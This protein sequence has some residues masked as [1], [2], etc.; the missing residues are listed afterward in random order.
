MIMFFILQISSWTQEPVLSPM[1]FAELRELEEQTISYDLAIEMQA[2]QKLAQY[3]NQPAALE[4]FL[5][6]LLHSNAAIQNYVTEVLRNIDPNI[7][8]AIPKAK[9]QENALLQ[10][11]VIAALSV[12]EHSEAPQRIFEL[13]DSQHY[14]CVKDA[15][16]ALV[17][18]GSLGK[19][20]IQ[21]IL[22]PSN[23]Q[24]Q[25]GM[26][27]EVLEETPCDLIFWPQI[28]KLTNYP[29]D[30]VQRRAV[31]LIGTWKIEAGAS[32]LQQKVDS[33]NGYI[34]AAVAWAIG[35]MPQLDLLSTLFEL[36][37]DPIWSVRCAAVNAIGN[38][39]PRDSIIACLV[40]LVDDNSIEVRISAIAQLGK[41]EQKLALAKLH[42]LVQNPQIPERIR[43]AC[44]EALGKIAHPSSLPLLLEIMEG[45][46]ESLRNAVRRS[47]SNFALI[48]PELLLEQ[49]KNQSLPGDL[50]VDL[51]TTFG[52]ISGI[53]QGKEIVEKMIPDVEKLAQSIEEPV[54][55]RIVA[56]KIM[57][58]ICPE[59]ARPWLK[60]W[61][62]DPAPQIQQIAAMSIAKLQHTEMIPELFSRMIDP[63]SQTSEFCLAAIV[64][65]DPT[66]IQPW[67]IKALQNSNTDINL[68]AIR[69]VYTVNMIEAIP[70]L[71]PLIEKTALRKPA[72][73]TL[74]H[75][76]SS[77][78][79]QSP[80]QAEIQRILSIYSETKQEK[81]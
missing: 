25:V 15:V 40:R 78:D 37:N 13:S 39:S 41:F 5:R 33:H 36:T 11:C 63:V 23:S 35:Q 73:K 2:Y 9:I 53:P 19:P 31:M 58:T 60:H 34:R 47:L 70:S 24:L 68:A 18:K 77:L 56:I 43:C 17:K 72:L 76:S 26:C 20:Y 30:R 59:K 69:V 28:A 67:I 14:L 32:I 22:D 74:E 50:R 29:D 81:P 49:I 44:C 57:V 21:K 65:M 45:K 7:I 27:M 10:R 6:G 16:R 12:L 52:K 71:I 55:L 62:Q 75:L 38:F 64:Q 51:L 1:S 8:F 3:T 80:Y 79:S 46:E 42:G 66:A 61:F 4:I 48:L 54:D